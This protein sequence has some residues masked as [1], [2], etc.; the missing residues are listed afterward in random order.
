MAY[1][2]PALPLGALVHYDHVLS[3]DDTVVHAGHSHGERAIS[4]TRGDEASSLRH[5]FQELNERLVIS[6]CGTAIA[7]D[8]V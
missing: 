1:G 3:N 5:L 7:S 6:S 4:E 8:S 2:Q